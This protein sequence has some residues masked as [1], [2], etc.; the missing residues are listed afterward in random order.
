MKRIITLLAV[1]ALAR[2]ASA[3]PADLVKQK[4]KAI[5]DQNNQQQGVVSPGAPSGTSSAPAPGNSSQGMSAAQQALLDRLQTDLNVIKT[6]GVATADEK[7]RVET[8][9]GLLAKGANKPSKAS[10]SKLSTDL[11]TALAEKPLSASDLTR[12]AKNINVVV[13]CG[14][15]T[16]ER[17]QSFVNESQIILKNS[18]VSAATVQL[19]SNDLNAIVVE[20]RKS[21]PKLFQ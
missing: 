17:A 11:T 18:G 13:N 3:D 20:I 6:G 10:L 9:I 16:P 14:F 1:M 21:K 19:I 8:D 2:I 12:L 7:L 4:A 15:L 5:R